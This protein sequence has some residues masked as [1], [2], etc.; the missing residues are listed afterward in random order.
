MAALAFLA[1]FLFS[2]LPAALTPNPRSSSAICPVQLPLNRAAP[3]NVSPSALI[4][5]WISA[6]KPDF[7]SQINGESPVGSGSEFGCDNG[8]GSASASSRETGSQTTA[9]IPTDTTAQTPAQTRP[10]WPAQFPAGILSTICFGSAAESN[11]ET[12]A[13]PV[14][15]SQSETSIEPK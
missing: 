12:A 4:P 6:L 13:V 11:R 2:T 8:A 9:E 1:V 15:A 3:L 14:A 5:G 10:E 7:Q